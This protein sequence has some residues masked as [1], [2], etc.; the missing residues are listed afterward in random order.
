MADELT[1]IMAA[2]AEAAKPAPEDMV[3]FMVA[4][5]RAISYVPVAH[6]QTGY[7]NVPP[8][9]PTVDVVQP[10]LVMRWCPQAGLA[11]GDCGAQAIADGKT[12]M[13]DWD[14]HLAGDVQ[15]GCRCG[16]NWTEVDA[17]Q[18]DG[19]VCGKVSGDSGPCV[20]RGPHNRSQEFL[21]GP[22]AEIHRN[23]AGFTWVTPWTPPEQQ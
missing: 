12:H 8:P 16:Y 10:F 17:S 3:A 15:H 9:G 14:G 21:G 4:A 11:Q 2:L 1:E 22:E 20:V 19:D 13:C 23:D 6:G 18:G 7:V 5:Q